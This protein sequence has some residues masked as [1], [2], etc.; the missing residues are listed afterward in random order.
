MENK[1]LPFDPAVYESLPI[2]MFLVEPEF[3][4]DGSPEDYRIVYGNAMFVKAWRRLYGERDC[5]GMH[6]EADHLLNDYALRMMGRF[7]AGSPAAFSIYVAQTNLHLHFQPVTGLPAPFMGYFLTDITDDKEQDAKVHFLRNIRQ[8]NNV[9]VLMRRHDDGHLEAVYA[10]APFAAM[11]ECTGEEALAR[12]DGM[13]FFH[14]THPEDRPL[15]RSMLKRRVSD[16]GNADLTIQLITAKGRR[17]WCN[18]HYAF[19]D[20]FGEQYIYCTYSN[21]TVLKQYEERL[22]SVYVSLGNNFY[23]MGERTLGLFRVNLTRDT[24]EEIKGRDLYDT[25]STR[26]PYSESL[27][28]RAEHFPIRSERERFRE[29]FDKNRLSAG[30]LEGKVSASMV[31]YSRRK[32]GRFCFVEYNAALTRHPLS[33]DMIAFITEQECNSE[34]VRETL[35]SK[36]LARQFDMVAYL[37]DGTYG[38]TIGDAAHIGRGSIFPITRSGDYGQYLDTQVVPVLDGTEEQRR[39]VREALSLNVVEE[40]TKHHEPYVVNIACNLDGEV[41][42]KRF[43]FYSI[44]PEAKFYIVLKSDTTEI[45]REQAR[46][47]E[48][49]RIA[50]EEA[51]QANVAKTAFLSSMSHEIR[52][53]MNAIIGLDNIALKDPELTPRAREHLEKIGVSARHLLGLIND[54]LDMSRIES[55]RMTLKSEEFSF[56][57]FLTQINTLVS[58]QCQDKGLWYDCR[59]EGAVDD[60][61]I[62]DDMK[63]KQ[64][65]INILGNAVKFTPSPG[66]VCLKIERPAQY[67]EQSTLRFTIRDTGIGMD[68][69]FLPHIFDAFSQEDATTTNRYGGSGLGMAITKNIVEMMNGNI[70]VTSK[71][72]EGTEFTVNVTL[73]NAERT[74][75]GNGEAQAELREMRVLVVDED[76][77]ACEHAKLVL[78]EAGIS[79][80]TCLSGREALDVIRLHHARREEYSLILVDLRLQERNGIDV[81][82]DIRGI[83]GKDSA[84]V[85][86]TAYNWEE[87]EEEARAA[88]VDSFLAKPLFA[89]GVMEAYR[90]A[91]NRR[92]KS[93]GQTPMAALE[94]RRILLAEDMAINAEIMI[95]LLEMH[96]MQVEHA[97]NGEAAVE[98]FLSHPEGYFDAIL[99]DVRMPVKDGLAATRDIRA[100]GR[101]DCADIPIIAMT[102]NAFD[103]DVQRSLQAGMDAH[104]TKPAEPNRLYETLSLL[105]GARE[106]E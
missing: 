13:G 36:I 103:E 14:S 62:G 1:S 23:Q 79:A 60:Y 66:Q 75:G 16:E 5:T 47:N 17:I 65:L 63:L 91:V 92:R 26:Y 25:D 73:R 49:L 71:K 2:S 54:I 6:I 24:F 64:V 19:I 53:P 104:L 34:K 27:R 57:D 90:Q 99:M 89:S 84:I 105:I 93:G 3:L 21:V 50:L 39:R 12:M 41:F 72:G 87:I 10:S 28:L 58:S 29:T 69:A 59:I 85:I 38:V 86:L 97:E 7:C 45:H 32:D 40:Q 31:I 83:V 76:S 102:A 67:R 42:H 81:T 106:K 82:R 22:R 68:E 80:D 33:G 11:M 20:D 46:R 96:E 37:V 95:E 4:A 43:D 70:S 101:S 78:E 100:S 35:M 15:V 74:E 44:D 56:R 52:T 48:Q 55:G 18:V 51:R 94:G 8:M 9:A 30:Y 77:I 88:G 98:A 61:Y